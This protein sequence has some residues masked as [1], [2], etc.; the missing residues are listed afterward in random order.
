MPLGPSASRVVLAQEKYETCNE[1]QNGNAETEEYQSLKWEA[2]VRATDGTM[3]NDARQATCEL[4][5]L[6]V[7]LWKSV[8]MIAKVAPPLE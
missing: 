4:S 6:A 1:E 8:V 5:P 7:K 3:A 2:E